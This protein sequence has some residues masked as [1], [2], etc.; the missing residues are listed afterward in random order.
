MYTVFK[1]FTFC[2]AHAVRGHTGGCQNLHGHNYRVRVYVSAEQLDGLGMVLDFADLKRTV[3]QIAGHF[4]H[5]TI[6]DH[7][8]FDEINPT[9]ELLSEFVY[10]RFQEEL[11]RGG[12]G[13]GRVRLGRV[14]VWENESSCAIFELPVEAS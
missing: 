7:P 9:A 12:L 3:A 5:Q 6:N 14:E 11:V 8:P 10:R 2:A 4:D 1:D 13:D